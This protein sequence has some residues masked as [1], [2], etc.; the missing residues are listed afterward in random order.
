MFENILA[1]LSP[2]ALFILV[3]IIIVCVILYGIYLGIMYLIEK[4]TENMKDI[5]EEKNKSK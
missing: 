2:E 4:I 3:I 1:F 5:K